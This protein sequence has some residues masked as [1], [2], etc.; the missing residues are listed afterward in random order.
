MSFPSSYVTSPLRRYVSPHVGVL[1]GVVS[2]VLLCSLPTECVLHEFGSPSVGATAPT[3][4]LGGSYIRAAEFAPSLQSIGSPIRV[5]VSSSA[6]AMDL[7]AGKVYVANSYSKTVSV[8]SYTAGFILA[9]TLSTPQNP[10]ALLIDETDHLLFVAGYNTTFGPGNG[11]VTAYYTTN[12]SRLGSVRVGALPWS[13]VLGSRQHELFVANYDGGGISVISL[14]PFRFVTSI[15]LTSD[16]LVYD[17]FRGMVYSSTRGLVGNVAEIDPG[18]N[19]IV[20]EI[21]VG[22]S[23]G[24][25]L[26]NP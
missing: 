8:I 25:L 3:F 26:V 15:N 14:T 11:T 19:S 10:D 20:G 2:L 1:L 13:M 17:P 24:A 6:V 21:S 16:G 4:G 12:D 18:T 9:D 22:G 5:G 7:A 23:P